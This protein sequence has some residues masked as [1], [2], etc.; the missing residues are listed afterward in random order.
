MF[1]INTPQVFLFPHVEICSSVTVKKQM[2]FMC[3]QPLDLPL[4]DLFQ[5]VMIPRRFEALSSS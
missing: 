1:R 3:Y 2:K 4:T 5:L